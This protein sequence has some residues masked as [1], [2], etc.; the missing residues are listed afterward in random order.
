[1]EQVL[2]S[3]IPP[4]AMFA[5]L[6]LFFIRPQ[7]KQ[8]QEKQQMLDQLKVGDKIM[9]AG[10]IHGTIVVV[11]EDVVT[12]ETGSTKSRIDLAKWAINSVVE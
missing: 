6:Y 3:L 10:G 7:K 9:T 11:K 12:I 1:M 4:V 5:V 8:E 2:K